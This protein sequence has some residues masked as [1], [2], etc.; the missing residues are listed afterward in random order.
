MPPSPQQQQ[1]RQAQHRLAVLRHA[2]EVTGNV[3]LTCRY[4]GISRTCFY[5]WQ[6]RYQDEG[7]DG[8][9]DR[10]SKPHHCPHATEAGVPSGS[11]TSTPPTAPARPPPPNRM[12][13]RPPAAV[14]RSG[15]AAACA[16]L[17]AQPLLLARPGVSKPPPFVSRAGSLS[18][19]SRVS[20]QAAT[21]PCPTRRTRPCQRR[22]SRLAIVPAGAVD[23]ATTCGSTR[24]GRQPFVAQRAGCVRRIVK[25]RA[26]AT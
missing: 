9:R 15:P 10:S 8:L 14:P 21:H 19:C 11:A 3:A 17:P 20:V 23:G 22:P 2:E 1:D 4:Y 7:L 18:S 13:P 24:E 16:P 5:K 6:R 26:S 25:V 12:P